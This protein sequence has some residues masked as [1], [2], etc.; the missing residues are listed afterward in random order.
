[1]SGTTPSDGATQIDKNRLYNGL[2]AYFSSFFTQQIIAKTDMGMKLEKWKGFYM[3][4]ISSGLFV[5]IAILT[6]AACSEGGPTT[7]PADE[8]I[9]NISG[10]VIACSSDTDCVV[11]EIDCCDHC[12]GGEVAAVNVAYAEEVSDYHTADCGEDIMCTL[13][14]CPDE[15]PRC[16]DGVCEHYTDT[17]GIF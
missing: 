2:S 10:S 14:S 15:L 4:K 5:F 12:N 11:V 3:K 7:P 16:S 8:D 6:F 1:M 17:S 13:M 9:V